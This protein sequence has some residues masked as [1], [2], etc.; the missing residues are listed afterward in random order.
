VGRRTSEG[1]RIWLALNRAFF[2]ELL[3]ICSVHPRSYISRVI[4]ESRGGVTASAVRIFALDNLMGVNVDAGFAG[5]RPLIGGV[6]PRYADVQ[7]GSPAHDLPPALRRASGLV[8]CHHDRDIP[9]E[10][11]G[12]VQESPESYLVRTGEGEPMRIPGPQI[13]NE[14]DKRP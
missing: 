3:R 13:V 6:I 10:R 9:A 12:T 7:T 14:L 5:D 8:V 11:S 1:A 2:V 4:Q